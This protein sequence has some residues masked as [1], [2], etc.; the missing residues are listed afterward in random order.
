MTD[1]Y[2]ATAQAYVDGVRSLSLP[3]AATRERGGL[4]A[5]VSYEELA[6]R[7][8]QLSSASD[9]LTTEAARKLNAAVELKSKAEA[10]TQLLAKVATDLEVGIYL[11]RAADNEDADVNLAQATRTERGVSS[12]VVDEQLLKIISGQAASLPARMERG[13]GLPQ[14]S[15]RARLMLSETVDNVL[16]SIRDQ[17]SETGKEAFKGV[18]GIGLGQIGQAAGHLG[19][20]IAQYFGQAEKLSR[21]YTL[22]RNFVSHAYD[23]IVALLGQNIA[24]AAGQQVVKWVDEVK[25]PKLFGNMIEWTFQ[26]DKTL[27]TLKPLILSSEAE[28]PKV[29]LAYEQVNA[30]KDSYAWQAGLANKTMKWLGYLGGIPAAILPYGPLILGTVYVGLRAYIVLL[31]ADYVDAERLKLLNRVAGVSRIVKANMIG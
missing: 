7:A 30:L 21:L 11:L 1:A 24:Q 16:L 27:A 9:S 6:N 17:A 29:A 15:K 20:G 13:A 5:P 3:R 10:S 4:L 25:E 23:S 31:G 22:F 14:D 18:L 2:T 8:D 12:A 26:I 19:L 28:R